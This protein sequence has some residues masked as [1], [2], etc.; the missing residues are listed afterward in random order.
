MEK[1]PYRSVSANLETLTGYPVTAFLD[2]P[3]FWYNHIHP[4]D[5]KN[6]EEVSAQIFSQAIINFDYRFQ[7]QSGNYIWLHDEWRAVYSDTGEIKEIIGS[8][9]DITRLKKAQTELQVRLRFEELLTSLITQFINSP[10]EQI[11]EAITHILTELGHYL[12]SDST[13]FYLISEDCSEL[14]NTYEW[15]KD[16]SEFIR[17]RFM[18]LPLDSFPWS[19]YQLKA[20]KNLLIDRVSDLPD[21]AIPERDRW[22]S[23]GLQTMLAIPILSRNRLIGFFGASANTPNQDWQTI[24]LA[25]FLLVRDAFA[26]VWIRIETEEQLRESEER[27]RLLAENSSDVISLH[28]IMTNRILYISPSCTRLTGY[29]PEEMLG[30]QPKQFIPPEDWIKAKAS[31]AQ[32]LKANLDTAVFEYQ[33]LHKSNPPFWVETTIQAIRNSDGEMIHF[34]SVTRDITRRK[35]DEEALLIAQN[36]LTLQVTEL[37]RRAQ[38]LA[39]LSEMGNMLQVC[40]QLDEACNVITQFAASLFPGTS[41]Y[42]ATQVGKTNELEVRQK[43]GQPRLIMRRFRLE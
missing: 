41:G 37:A 2:N 26:S 27:F 15:Q 7:H 18:G 16:Q 29:Q 23:Q 19:I 31:F 33:F 28:Q 40:S 39:T 6:V 8:T 38:E 4:D 36:Q 24:D 5:L 13:F 32:M 9:I 14:T 21:D 30:Q 1:F 10:R 20:G 34:V 25:P 12:R 35:I 42:I 22:L 11:D 3:D 43:W 17:N